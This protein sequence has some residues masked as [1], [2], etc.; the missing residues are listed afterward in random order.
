MVVRVV[1]L[2]VEPSRVGVAIAVAVAVGVA[3][4]VGI[5]RTGREWCVVPCGFVI[6]CVHLLVAIVI[7][8]LEEEISGRD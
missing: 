3:V 7:D 2:L 6:L 5:G 1:R 8:S 4:G